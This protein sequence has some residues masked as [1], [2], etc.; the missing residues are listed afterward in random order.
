MKRSSPAPL[1]ILLFDRSSET[2][3]LVQ[4]KLRSFTRPHEVTVASSLL[5]FR[6]LLHQRSPHVILS[7]LEHPDASG[8]D[9]L[10]ESRGIIAHIP[11]I[12]LASVIDEFRITTCLESGADDCVTVDHLWRLIPAIERSLAHKH[13]REEARQTVSLIRTMLE[14][15]N[16]GVVAFDREMNYTYVNP[17]AGEMLGRVPE[18]LIGRNYWTEYPE[19]KGTP[20]AN[21]YMQ[22]L[23]TQQP[24]VLEEHYAPWNRWFENRIYSSQE[25]L[26]VFFTEITE[27]KLAEIALRHSEQLL[28][29]VFETVPNGIAAVD[30]ANSIVMANAEAER[31]LRLSKSDI[32]T[33]SYDDIQWKITSE[34]GSPFP[35]EELPVAK[36]LSTG[37]PV[38]HVEH[39]IHHAD[40]SRAALSI[41][42]APIRATSGEITS[43]VMSIT[44]L[45]ERKRA[46]AELQHE[47]DF[48][49]GVLDSLPGILYCYDDQFR[50]VRWN[51]NFER[52]SGYSSAE[53][54][55]MGPLDYFRGDDRDL[56]RSRIGEVFER[57]SSN[58]EA[59]F[60]SKDGTRT[61]Y[62]LTGVTTTMAGK[63]HLVGTGIDISERRRAERAL[64]SGEQK[65]STIFQKAPFAAALSRVTD[66][67]IVEINHEFEVLF[68]FSRIETLGKT[69]LELGLYADPAIRSRSADLMRTEGFVRNMEMKL[70]TRSGEV[71]DFLVSTEFVEINEERHVLTTSK[72]I[73]DRK[74]SEA[75]LRE[76]EQR[77]R[78]FIEHA[79]AALAMFDRE[80]RYLAVSKRWLTDYGL[81]DGEITG[82]SHYE[83]FPEITEGWKSVH[84]RGLRGEIVEADEDRF[85]R[86]DGSVQWIRWSVRPWH[87]TDGNVGGI[88][89]FTE[90]ITYRKQAENKVEETLRDVRALS[91]RL[92]EIREE[93]RTRIA[94]EI[95][96]DLGQ[97]L[98]A[99]KIDLS[100]ISSRLTLP[101]PLM[102]QRLQSTLGLADSLIG[103]VQR[104]ATELRLGI[105]DDF[106]LTAALEWQTEEFSKRTG[107]E[108]TIESVGEL[109][110]LPPPMAT[111]GF[112]IVQEALTNIVR[113]A[114][115]RRVAV[116]LARVGDNLTLEVS[117]DGVGINSEDI[118]NTRS[119]GLIGIRER[120]LALG[121]RV[122]FTGTPGKGT[123]VLVSLPVRPPAEKATA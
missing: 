94:R 6:G 55:R 87:V 116:R 111:A 113:H 58:V 97:S 82:H 40:G 57:G 114:R 32:A 74:K 41:N 110:D 4:D 105:L 122:E 43:V 19:A 56:V 78:L 73:T 62:Y 67:V 95:H 44:D 109:P 26:T 104:I 120:A 108:C 76:S 5:E 20:F 85:D 3:R 123:T 90:D 92:Q 13:E 107:I 65:F 86:A 54:E 16:D 27:R 75:A 63:R 106:G 24:V 2:L 14:R 53:I 72:D 59:D 42:A 17:K 68:G 10:R 81:K 89:I 1:R 11:F 102:T 28:K 84:Q 117:D 60:V 30:R 66:G 48:A 115:A 119:L 49:N 38:F 52:V 91:A 98:T 71:R 46:E 112:R 33:R 36:V 23:E 29:S 101:E 79:P 31:L 77:M 45:T 83:I 51:K 15:I 18:D 21:A 80:M 37:R 12:L 93:E 8:L 34:N 50:F 100:W 25:G 70:R 103:S 9:I 96:D 22:A 88:V 118:V 7:A 35:K 64:R 61:P 39:A 47:R 99:L 121:G 69:S